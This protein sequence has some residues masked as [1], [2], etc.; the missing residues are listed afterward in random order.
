ME[1]T[2]VYLPFNT[3]VNIH[4]FTNAAFTQRITLTPE[5][6]SPLVYTGSGE[7]DHPIGQTVIQTP[8]SGS[9]PRGYQVTV[10]VESQQGGGWKPSSVGQGS[11]GIMYYSAILVISEDLIDNDWNDG[12]AMFTWWVPPPQ[13]Q[14]GEHSET[15]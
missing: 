14:V 2:V 5:K 6:G 4:L 7:D 1:S 13:R 15:G 9:N 8:A 11:C 3:R 12:V 10:K